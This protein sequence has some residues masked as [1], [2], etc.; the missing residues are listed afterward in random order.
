VPEKRK[1]NKLFRCM[2]IFPKKTKT[3]E[4]IDGFLRVFK[5]LGWRLLALGIISSKTNDV[6]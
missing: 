6:G 5:T 2:Q 4:N 3:I 1:I